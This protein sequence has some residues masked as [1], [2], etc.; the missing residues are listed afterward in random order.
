MKFEKTWI[1]NF[2]LIFIWKQV[3][4]IAQ[5]WNSNTILSW[6]S[7]IAQRVLSFF[8]VFQ[9][10]AFFSSEFFFFFLLKSFD[11]YTMEIKIRLNLFKDYISNGCSPNMYHTKKQPYKWTNY[12]I[13]EDQKMNW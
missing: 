7:S 5:Y 12:I 3:E 6:H 8:F 2:F 4:Q 13:I 11:R 10:T 1:V 9:M